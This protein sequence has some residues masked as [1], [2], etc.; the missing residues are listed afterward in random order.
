MGRREGIYYYHEVLPPL[1]EKVSDWLNTPLL[2][3][4]F[5]I[6][7]GLILIILRLIVDFFLHTRFV[8]VYFRN[9]SLKVLFYQLK[10]RLQGKASLKLEEITDI[11]LKERLEILLE[12]R[13]QNLTFHFTSKK[14]TEGL[15][16]V[17]DF[18]Q[19]FKQNE[20]LEIV[21]KKKKN[22]LKNENKDT[23][24]KKNKKKVKSQNND[25][26]EANSSEES[27]RKSKEERRINSKK[28]KGK[29]NRRSKQD[30][31]DNKS[32]NKNESDS[33]NKSDGK[34]KKVSRKSINE[35]DKTSEGNK[36]TDSNIN[37]SLTIDVTQELDTNQ[38]KNIYSLK[39]L[40]TCK[41]EDDFFDNKVIKENKNIVLDL[42]NKSVRKR[43][44]VID[45][46]KN[47]LKNNEIENDKPFLIVD[48]TQ[49]AIRVLKLN[50]NLAE[51]KNI[52]IKEFYYYLLF[53]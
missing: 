10:N 47:K 46:K 40:V 6:H 38:I 29:N 9:K 37:T 15:R 7:A 11:E 52:I 31:T 23:V 42:I 32:E 24:V 51:L 34:N 17:V 49:D 28:R 44:S 5:L 22:Q 39:D 33:E 25:D 21:K 50:T 48:S 20:L 45:I 35:D 14:K 30:D 27:T 26:E 4:S 13:E 12:C 18:I 8:K 36:K 41:S 3:I 1:R 2:R 43:A 16:Q 19:K 53:Y